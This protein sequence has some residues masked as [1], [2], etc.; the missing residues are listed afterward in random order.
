MTEIEI[1]EHKGNKFMFVDGYLWMWDIPLEKEIQKE[2]AEKASGDVLV[3]GYGF[4][5][6]TKFLLDNP[7]VNSVTT[8]EKYK[9]VIDKMK[10]FDEIYGD[11][12]INDFF[13]LPEDKK[14]DCIIGDIWPDI[15]KKFLNDYTRFKEKAEKLLKE[16]GIILAW[17]QDYFEY[18]LKKD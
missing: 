11:I 17:G 10:E 9:E 3:A 1:I 7:K 14:F 6:L 5:I 18:L 12:I 16:N 15:N 8:V 2:L 13:D 4:G